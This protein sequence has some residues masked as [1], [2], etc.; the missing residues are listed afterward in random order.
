MKLR[1][2]SFSGQAFKEITQILNY[3]CEKLLLPFNQSAPNC[4]KSPEVTSE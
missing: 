1:G 3:Y 2:F 4:T